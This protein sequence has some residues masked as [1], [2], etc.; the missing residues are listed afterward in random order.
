[1]ESCDVRLL[2]ERV[3]EPL[4]RPDEGDLVALADAELPGN[5]VAV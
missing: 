1:M 2:A 5:G 3:L 4:G